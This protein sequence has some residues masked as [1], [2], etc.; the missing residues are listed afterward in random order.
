M[1]T[2]IIIIII[3]IAIIIIIVIIITHKAVKR[4]PKAKSRT[5]A[6]RPAITPAFRFSAIFRE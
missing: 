1:I 3:I 2:I 6:P 4:R 5:V